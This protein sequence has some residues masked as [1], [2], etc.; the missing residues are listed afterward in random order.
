MRFNETKF[1][2]VMGLC[3]ILSFLS[4]QIF[5]SPIENSSV[6]VRF[7]YQSYEGY[8][9][10]GAFESRFTIPLPPKV[11]EGEA[12]KIA[13]EN[14]EIRKVMEMPPGDYILF[15]LEGPYTDDRGATW[16]PWKVG[17]QRLVTAGVMRVDWVFDVDAMTGAVKKLDEPIRFLPFYPD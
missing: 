3:F 10:D 5:A 4:G 15:I 2:L 17:V 14:R 6:R 12:L 16:S 13:R 11:D 8:K 7:Y 1:Y 9:R